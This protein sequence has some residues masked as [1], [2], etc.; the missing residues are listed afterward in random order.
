MLE[1]NKT[2][3][4][5][6]IQLMKQINDKSINLIC[7]DLPYSTTACRWDSLIPFPELWEQYERIITDTGAIVLTA[8]Q[9]F[10]SQLVMSNLKLFKFEQIWIKSKAFDF[11]N[12]KARPMK[13]HESVLVFSKGQSNSTAIL[14]KKMTY[15]PQGLKPFGKLVNGDKRNHE[16]DKKGHRIGRKSQCKYIQQFTNYP[17]SVL[18]FPSEGK[19]IHP[20]QKPV[21][22]F[23]YLI[24]TYSNEGDTVLDNCAG[25]GTTGVACQNAGRNYILMEKDEEYFKLIKQ[26]INEK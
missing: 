13:K 8:S 15:N 25:S 5:D 11:L 1:L 23:E 22:L 4:G 20:T 24:R 26:R 2:Y 17:N 7:C 16:K 19:T 6:C 14:E 21:P 9:P 18:E 12:A 10:T 3:Q